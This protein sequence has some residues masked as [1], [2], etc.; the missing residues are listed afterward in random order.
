MVAIIQDKIKDVE[1][2]CKQYGVTKLELFGSAATGEFN[3][4]TSD[5][6]FLI[7]FDYSKPMGASNQYFGFLRAMEDLFGRS[8][9]LVCAKAMRNR[10]FIESVNQSRTPI[11]DQ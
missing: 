7:E 4:E 1:A 6:D 5:L 11:Y 10:F 2:L 9:D 8:V 3:E